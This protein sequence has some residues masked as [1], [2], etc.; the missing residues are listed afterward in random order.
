[1]EKI[2]GEADPLEL[3]GCN[4]LFCSWSFEPDVGCWQN[5]WNCLGRWTLTCYSRALQRS[6]ELDIHRAIFASCA[7]N[8]LEWLDLVPRLECNEH[9]NNGLYIC[10]LESDW[11][12]Q[13]LGQNE[14]WLHYPFWHN[15]DQYDFALHSLGGGLVHGCEIDSQPT[16]YLGNHVCKIFADK[17][18]VGEVF[19]QKMNPA[20]LDNCDDD[21]V[22]GDA[23][24]PLNTICW[25]WVS[26]RRGSMMYC[27]LSYISS[28]W[29]LSQDV[30]LWICLDRPR[31]CISSPSCLGQWLSYHSFHKCQPLVHYCVEDVQSLF[32]D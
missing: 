31:G 13:D 29:W 2:C 30:L 10:P 26:Y 16:K 3:N 14:S 19:G 28:W 21:I 8:L 1:M 5:S 7:H 22:A 11:I 20:F 32:L 17:S 4:S 9:L 23:I 12:C 15:E 24:C 27:W 25:D 6:I 18:N